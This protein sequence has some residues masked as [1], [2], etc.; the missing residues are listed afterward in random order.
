M[1]GVLPTPGLDKALGL[2]RCKSAI[3]DMVEPGEPH[4]QPSAT[5]TIATRGGLGGKGPSVG[6]GRQPPSRA[7]QGPLIRGAGCKGQDTKGR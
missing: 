4:S 3:L 2:L 6:P 5:V 1:E 7:E